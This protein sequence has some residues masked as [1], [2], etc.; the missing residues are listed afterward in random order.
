MTRRALSFSD[1]QALMRYRSIFHWETIINKQGMFESYDV[2]RGTV[3]WSDGYWPD[4][5]VVWKLS[6]HR[7]HISLAGYMKKASRWWRFLGS[8][9]FNMISNIG[10]AG[11]CCRSRR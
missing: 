3:S 7:F 9:N 11:S 10:F 1:L 5:N 6:I 4:G 8:E 2:P